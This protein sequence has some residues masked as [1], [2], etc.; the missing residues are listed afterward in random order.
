MAANLQV[1]PL[2]R[3][4]KGPQRRD[5]PRDGESLPVVAC[6]AADGGANGGK[7]ETHP[8]MVMVSYGY[9]CLLMDMI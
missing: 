3:T 6:V 4:V 9:I 1:A 5:P 7:N 8:V 2:D